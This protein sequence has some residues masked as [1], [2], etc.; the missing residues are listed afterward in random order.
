MSFPDYVAKF[1]RKMVEIRSR[2]KETPHHGLYTDYWVP[3]T[4]DSSSPL[5]EPEIGLAS[6]SS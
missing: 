1:R 5:P 2:F 4:S 3:A 6:S